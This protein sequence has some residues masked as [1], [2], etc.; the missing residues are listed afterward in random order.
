MPGD[1][2]KTREIAAVTARIDNLLKSSGDRANEAKE[3]RQKLDLVATLERDA[4][5]FARNYSF[6]KAGNILEDAADTYKFLGMKSTASETYFAAAGHKA[7]AVLKAEV[8]NDRQE[9]GPESIAVYIREKEQNLVEIQEIVHQ[10]RSFLETFVKSEIPARKLTDEMRQALWKGK[11]LAAGVA[12]YYITEM[13]IRVR[14]RTL[15]SSMFGEDAAKFMF[16][17]VLSDKGEAIAVEAV[18]KFNRWL[19]G[20]YDDAIAK[21]THIKHGFTENSKKLVG[22][23]LEQNSKLKSGFTPRPHQIQ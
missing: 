18:D 6:G 21:M 5:A 16:Y 9:I 12:L 14:N 10:A 23:M 4:E 11:G 1:G 3:I 22:E 2:T 8:R 20:N 13:D 15:Y 17:A 7:S 19:I